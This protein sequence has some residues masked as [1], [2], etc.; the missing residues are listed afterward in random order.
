MEEEKSTSVKSLFAKPLFDWWQGLEDNDRASRAVLRRCATLDAVTL[1]DAYQRFYRYMLARGWP[2]NASEWQRDKLAAIAG[3]VAHVKKE[4]TQR[5]PIR[6]SELKG[7]RPLVS[8][9]RFR[10]LLKVETTDDL[11]TSLRRI[12]PLVDHQADIKRL[13]DDVYG[14]ND[15]I[16]KQWAYSYRWPVKKSA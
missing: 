11:F 10:N 15:N 16:K 12:L 5:L 7:D 13:A 6:M 1:S 3:L 9:M 14:W 8:E 4:D 2:E